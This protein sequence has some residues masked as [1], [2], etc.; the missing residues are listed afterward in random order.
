MWWGIVQHKCVLRDPVQAMC[1]LESL[2]VVRQRIVSHCRTLTV[3]E[4]NEDKKPRAVGRRA[5]EGAVHC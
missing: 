1:Y 2:P 5:F 3:R 4:E